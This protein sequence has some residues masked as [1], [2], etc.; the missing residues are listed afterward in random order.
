MESS[1][2]ILA[3]PTHVNIESAAYQNLSSNRG[4][5]GGSGAVQKRP[6]SAD[7]KVPSDAWHP[8]DPGAL[9]RANDY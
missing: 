4:D 2:L 8:R 5:W 1:S 9:Q 6:H 7:P 3:T